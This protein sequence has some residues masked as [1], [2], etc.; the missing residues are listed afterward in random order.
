[1]L[2]LHVAVAIV[3]R[4]A[5]ALHYVHQRRDADGR[6]LGLVH[7][8]VSPENVMVRYDGGVKLIDFGIARMSA[9]TL[10][11]RTNVLK[12]KV[13][14]MSPE[15]LRQD[16]LD[17]R[18]D[19]FQLGVVMYELTTGTRLF[20]GENFAAVMNRVLEGD[21][22]SPRDHDPDYPPELEEIVLRA[23]AFEPED[24]YAS[25]QELA[26]SLAQVAMRSSYR[27][28]DA[29]IGEEMTRRFGRSTSPDLSD[30][31]DPP[32]TLAEVAAPRRRRAVPWAVAGLLAGG[33]AAGAYALTR[34]PGTDGAA[35]EAELAEVW[36][37]GSRPHFTCTLNGA[38]DLAQG[39]VCD[40]ATS[41]CAYPD[42]SCAAGLRIGEFGGERSG[43]CTRPDAP[44]V[45]V[46]WRRSSAPEIDGDPAESR[47]GPGI[48]LHGDFG[49]TARV[50]LSWDDEAMY[51]SADVVDPNV[52]STAYGGQLLW[53][54]DGIELMCD[55]ARD[56]S[57][58][59]IPYADDFKFVIT[60]L[61]RVGTSWGGIVPTE[62]WDTV[63]R[64]ATR[65]DATVNQPSD[66]DRG[67]S[68]ELAVEWD[69]TFRRPAAGQAWGFNIKV[70]DHV[71]PTA[72]MAQWR[73]EGPF[74]H[75][76][77]AGTLLFADGEVPPVPPPPDAAVPDVPKYE[78]IDLAT[79]VARA[80][81]EFSV[82][83]PLANL[84]DGC[85]EQRPDCLGGVADGT[86]WAVTFDLGR[87]R[88]LGFARLFGDDR[89]RISSSW[90]LSVREDE[91]DE[92][93]R[94]FGRADAFGS[95]W[96]TRDVRGTR[97]RFVRLF[98]RG[99]EGA[100]AEAAEFELYALPVEN[101]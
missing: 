31:A 93:T 32:T 84:F 94:V 3:E 55:T 16:P 10:A 39:G 66:E 13:G 100:G 99:K 57:P 48:V 14:Y 20:D 56:R 5:S 40:I 21:V 37:L 98:V 101:M 92:W 60:A 74:N 82:A 18:S 87:V 42:D 96:F 89:G 67:Y 25:A 36:T 41:S 9:R 70:N 1:M 81:P 58:G 88:D 2:P 86:Q 73:N 79:L 15:Q 44:G 35:T 38:C 72:R 71:A 8:D 30:V 34:A 59:R 12:G 43:A 49:V 54:H 62:A 90:S 97:A 29:A 83:S 17:H 61:N 77:T 78:R 45:A 11:T 19:V 26:E 95:R 51:V 6:E 80:K 50:W 64:S 27:T 63:V 85:H 24:R 22:A 75:P 53:H 91:S 65:A 33:L 46:A 23:L 47:R 7:R 69:N 52:Q 68:V 28:T 4:I 76:S